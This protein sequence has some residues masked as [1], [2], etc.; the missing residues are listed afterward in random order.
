MS[1]QIKRS[2]ALAVADIKDLPSLSQKLGQPQDE[3]SQYLNGGFSEATH[4]SLSSWLAQRSDGDR[5]VSGVVVQEFNT[6]IQGPLIY[7]EKRFSSVSL[8]TS[9]L[10]L[11]VRFRAQRNWNQDDAQ[12]FNQVLIKDAYPSEIWR[13]W[14]S[15]VEAL[16]NHKDQAAWNEAYEILW[17]VANRAARKGLSLPEAD[18]QAIAQGAIMAIQKILLESLKPIESGRALIGLTAQ[19]SRWDARDLIRKKI[20]RKEVELDRPTSKDSTGNKR[21][22]VCP[23]PTDLGDVPSEHMCREDDVEILRRAIARLDERQRALLQA[24]EIDGRSYEELQQQFNLS[25]DQV[26]VYLK[27]AREKLKAFFEEEREKPL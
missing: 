25:S 12:H 8:S 7:N 14:I 21:R 20:S 4:R 10:D 18:I 27:R 23:V 6:V 15:D 9:A 22:T 2:F 13:I 24:R 11:Y 17:S 16:K 3:F 5:P 26:G 1:A 19:R